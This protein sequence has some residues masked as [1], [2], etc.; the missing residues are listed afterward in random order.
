MVVVIFGDQAS[1]GSVT[2]VDRF[3][4]TVPPQETAVEAYRTD[5]AKLER[6]ANENATLL[7]L[8][9]RGDAPANPDPDTAHRTLRLRLTTSDE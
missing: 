9:Y 4:T 2:E 6:N 8:L 7:F 3:A 1:S 5:P